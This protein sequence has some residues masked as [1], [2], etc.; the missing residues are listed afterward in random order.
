[1]KEQGRPEAKPE[2]KPEEQ[3]R[4]ILEIFHLD[5]SAAVDPVAAVRDEV[6]ALRATWASDVEVKNRLHDEL[7][8]LS[9]MGNQYTIGKLARGLAIL[10]QYADP[11]SADEGECS[12]RH[13]QIF[14]SVYSA[15]KARM[16]QT[17]EGK[18]HLAEL[19]RLGWSEYGEVDSWY[20]WT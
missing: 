18:A 20:H 17:D 15:T 14:A 9:G 16:E 3:I 2:A 19:E 11:E 12:A 8:A 6:E 5:S 10:C 13:D 4:A 1:M 7:L